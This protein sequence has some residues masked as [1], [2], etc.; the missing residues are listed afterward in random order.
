[1]F[2][3][4][5]GLFLATKL[6]LG[7]V[8]SNKYLFSKSSPRVR[9]YILQDVKLY[10]NLLK[11]LQVVIKSVSP[12]MPFLSRNDAKAKIDS[13][14]IQTRCSMQTLFAHCTTHKCWEKK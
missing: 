10:I 3:F 12:G 8:H 4:W 13:S 6:V 14:A 11:C 5:E 1:M 9:S 2:S 7:S